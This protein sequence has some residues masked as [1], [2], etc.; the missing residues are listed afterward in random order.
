MYF[1]SH[2]IARYD[3]NAEYN[4]LKYGDDTDEAGY[5]YRIEEPHRDPDNLYSIPLNGILNRIP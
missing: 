4:R 2:D 3:S 5:D 1:M